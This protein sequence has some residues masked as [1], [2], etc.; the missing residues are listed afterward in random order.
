MEVS[1][2]T[3]DS[4]SR[5]PPL[6]SWASAAAPLGK[7]RQGLRCSI[8]AILPRLSA[9]SL[10]FSFFH[11]FQKWVVV[12]GSFTIGF[13]KNVIEAHGNL[14]VQQEF[15]ASK[16]SIRYWR[17]QKQRI[18]CCTKNVSWT[19]F[20]APW[21]G[22]TIRRIYPEAVCKVASYNSEEHPRESFRD[23]ARLWATKVQFKGSQS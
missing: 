15:G 18:A 4:W 23:S 2:A 7:A 19:D 5:K 22:N 10:L 17:N 9:V 14:V 16:K 20:S 8:N 12:G 11:F 6:L 3:I 1:L 21:T 13:K